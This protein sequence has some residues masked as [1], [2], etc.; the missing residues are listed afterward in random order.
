[1]TS[2]IGLILLIV[3]VSACAG[4]D[5]RTM[6]DAIKY[7]ADV[8][9]ADAYFKEIIT[10]ADLDTSM[11][12][13]RDNQRRLMP[14]YVGDDLSISGEWTPCGA[15]GYVFYAV[16]SLGDPNQDGLPDCC[17]DGQDY[18]AGQGGIVPGCD[19]EWVVV[20][21]LPGQI[22]DGNGDGSIDE[23]DLQLFTLCSVLPP[24]HPHTDS[25]LCLFDYNNSG[26]LTLYDFEQLQLALGTTV[27]DEVVLH[28]G[29][30]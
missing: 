13:G 9:A 14:D 15:N 29:A 12:I 2:R 6:K 21:P 22:G 11:C 8:E 23:V 27:Y 5:H 10:L 18:G 30:P 16:E 19:S 25:C 17:W 3:V 1:M 20:N 24:S 7:I 28:W 26:D 4:P